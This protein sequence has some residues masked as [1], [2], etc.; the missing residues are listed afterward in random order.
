M[1][2]TGRRDKRVRLENPVRE[3]D[4]YGRYTETWSALDPAEVFAHLSP[5]S[6]GDLERVTAGTVI[7]TAAFV[8]TL[9]YHPQVT[10]HTRITYGARQFQV[11]SLR[12]ADEASRELVL[13]AE[14]ILPGPT[15]PVVTAVRVP[16]AATAGRWES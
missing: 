16:S 13:V 1:I 9:L 2:A 6:A 12:N 4:R 14:E 5:A 8:V 15:A 3:P 7:A 10:V 11:K